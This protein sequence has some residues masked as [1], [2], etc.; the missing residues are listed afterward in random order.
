[1]RPD[2]SD[3]SIELD[4]DELEQIPD[5][6]G[7][8]HR[9][10]RSQAAAP[11]PRQGRASDRSELREAPGAGGPLLRE[12]TEPTF[13]AEAHAVAPPPARQNGVMRDKRE[14]PQKKTANRVDPTTRGHRSRS[15]QPTRA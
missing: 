12:P 5:D 4:A 2:P 3:I 9:A 14:S 6:R 8:D 13:D 15:E 1:M 7:L 10:S 11:G